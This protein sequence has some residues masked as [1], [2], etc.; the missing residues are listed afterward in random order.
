M[1]LLDFVQVIVVIV[2]F[3]MILR[4]FFNNETFYMVFRLAMF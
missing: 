3:L 4:T 2:G 1:K